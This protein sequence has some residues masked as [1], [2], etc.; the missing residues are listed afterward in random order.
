[1]WPGI[2]DDAGRMAWPSDYSATSG[3]LL[4]RS[5]VFIGPPATVYG[6]YVYCS[7]GRLGG[8]A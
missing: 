4:N 2:R 6:N 7:T 3:R 5:H 1:M 8:H